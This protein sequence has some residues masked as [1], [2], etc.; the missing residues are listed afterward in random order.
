MSFVMSHTC[1]SVLFSVIEV[2]V[3]EDQ[4]YTICILR[5]G[6]FRGQAAVLVNLFLFFFTC[7]H[8]S[9]VMIVVIGIKIKNKKCINYILL[10]FGS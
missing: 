7:L 1:A 9:S 3:D 8:Y 2:V 10:L 6:I 5:R 4:L